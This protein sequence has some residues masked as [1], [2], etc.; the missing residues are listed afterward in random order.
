[1]Q[2]NVFIFFLLG[3]G[4]VSACS[5][6]EPAVEAAWPHGVKYEIFPLAFADGN[7]DGKGDLKGLTEKLD[8]IRDLGV[9]GIWLMPIMPSPSYH[10]YDVS[11]YK[12]IHPDYGTLGDFKKMTEEA[13]RRGIRVIIDLVLNHTS[14]YHP[15][16]ESA[17]KGKD[18]PYRDYYVWAD[19]DS[20]QDQI[21]KKKITLDSD[22]IR[23]WHEVN[24]QSTA[25]HYYG[26]FSSH[27]PDLNF[28]NQKV[29]DEMVEVA[30][31]WIEEMKVDGF[32]FDAA[33]H[34]YPDD[35]N[36]D[37]HQF[38]QWYRKELVKIKPDIYMVGEVYSTDRNEVS[39]YAKGLPALFNF[40]LGS[41]VISILNYRQDTLQLI[42]RYA[43]QIDFFRSSNPEFLDAP[44]LTNHDQN[45]VMSQLGDH[46]RKA[47]V[48][49]SIL[50]TLPGTPYV[51]Y[52]EELGMR[53]TKPDEFIREPFPWDDKKYTT[54]WM[55]LKFNVKDSIDDVNKQSK[56]SGS[57]LNHYKRLIAYRNSS[58]P[59][60]FGSIESLKDLP[61]TIIASKR[62]FDSETVIIF[63]NISEKEVRLEL[64]N[65]LKQFRSLEF[66]S[67]DHIS[68]R[69]DELV[70]PAFST[71]ILKQ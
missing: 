30:R 42:D 58:R 7:S 14:T 16:F 63:H 27:M 65:E 66:A 50:L 4:L 6:S 59:L 48:A 61:R 46:P 1:M 19:K 8:Y 11:D 35:R 68:F 9:N 12:N 40:D 49:A 54:W 70:L 5:T 36:Y 13:H 53:G 22:N 31:F 25:E 71:V 41:S 69:E 57:L 2:R 28:D 39:P 26:F 43:E 18:S 20:I 52:G 23:Q 33:R 29:R 45:R 67:D 60:T 64:A 15:W 37:S 38:W 3:F 17:V 62:S 44:I 56:D 34:I 47:K 21:S 24:G 51:Y 10:K 32:R 55:N